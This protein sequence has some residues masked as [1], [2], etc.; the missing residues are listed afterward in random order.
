M[1]QS[2]QQRRAADTSPPASAVM[3]AFPHN[4]TGFFS[5]LAEWS[6]ARLLSFPFGRGSPVSFVTAVI[7]S[8]P[9]KKTAP[10]DHDSH[11]L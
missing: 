4:I 10:H 11:Y 8:R 1:R 6:R 9:S 5:T 2:Y 3:I 7:P